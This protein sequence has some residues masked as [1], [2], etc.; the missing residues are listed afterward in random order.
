MPFP[1]RHNT[2][3]IEQKSESYLRNKLPQEWTIDRPQNDY[4]KDFVIGLAENGELR[5]LE[6]VVQ[7]KASYRSSTSEDS[8]KIQLK[9][10]S[11]NYLRGL[12]TV[13][14]LIKYTEDSNEAYWIFLRDII[15]PRNPTQA[16]FTVNIPRNNKL[17]VID[18]HEKVQ[19]IREV[20]SLKLGAING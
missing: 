15:G 17:S 16:T 7:L 4:G 11:Y 1:Q 3:I 6:M 20:T 2:H 13:V 18:W 9:T 5:G 10:S 8:E 19:Y 14:M 12:L